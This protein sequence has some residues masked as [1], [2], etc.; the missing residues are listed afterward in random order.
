MQD[1]KISELSNNFY[2]KGNLTEDF[3]IEIIEIETNEW[4]PSPDLPSWVSVKA[5]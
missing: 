1:I 5:F 2:R 3:I 4:A